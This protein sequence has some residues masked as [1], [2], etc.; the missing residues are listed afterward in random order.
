MTKNISFYD[1]KR[2]TNKNNIFLRVRSPDWKGARDTLEFRLAGP[3]RDPQRHGPCL[4]PLLSKTHPI[5]RKTHLLLSKTHPRFTHFCPKLTHNFNIFLH[6]LQISNR[7]APQ[8]TLLGRTRVAYVLSTTFRLDRPR[9]PWTISQG[10]GWRDPAPKPQM[11]KKSY[12]K[13][14][15]GGGWG[16]L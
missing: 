11:T 3:Q 4:H 6:F 15:S 1:I 10:R 7:N 13:F 5:L 2:P 12:R 9:L 16:P 14:A 8:P